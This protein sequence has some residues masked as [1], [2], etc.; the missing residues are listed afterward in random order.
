MKARNIGI[1]AAI[2]VVAGGA[3][4][5]TFWYRRNPPVVGRSPTDLPTTGVTTR[6]A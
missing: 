5:G 6:T 3:I 1:V 4:G 2:V